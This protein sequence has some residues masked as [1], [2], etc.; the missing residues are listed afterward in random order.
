MSLSFFRPHAV[1]GAL[2]GA[3]LGFGALNGPA[4]AADVKDNS[5][6]PDLSGHYRVADFGDVNDDVLQALRSRMAGFLDSEIR[7]GRGVGQN[8]ELFIKSGATGRF[9]GSPSV[10]LRHG[11]DFACR[12]GWVEVIQPVRTSRKTEQGW[13]EGQSVVLLN[14]ASPKGLRL[15]VRVSGGQRTTLYQY[16][17]ARLSL[18][19]PGTGMRLNESIRWPDVSEPAPPRIDN[20][21]PAPEA[22]SVAQ[23]RQRL[24]ATMLGPVVLTGLKPDAQG[25]QASLKA[26][27]TK[28]VAAFEDRLRSAGMG[29]RVL[30]QP[31]WSNNAQEFE[32]LIL[33]AGSTAAWRPSLLWVENELR[34]TRHPNA[35][36]T[37]SIQ[38]DPQGY[39]V[40][41]TLS[42]V[43]Q[44]QDVATHIQTRSG[45]FA[46]VQVQQ[47]VEVSSASGARTAQLLLVM[48]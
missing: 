21:P 32:L 39:R 11:T 4:I 48:K 14:R 30:R 8:W 44:A 41:F 36:E 3:A 26:T 20:T 28:Q 47:P 15:T 25:V 23:T 43:T 17:S 38:A 18:P 37:G 45:A 33:P 7:F 9:P 5:A 19:V 42:G 29:Y 2:A 34:R 35:A 24:S 13:F 1:A 40:V 27:Q 31:L 12:D 10:T 16:D 6:C 22:P 46:E